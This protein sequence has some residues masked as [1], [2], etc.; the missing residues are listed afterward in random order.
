M[1][2]AR[3]YTCNV[4]SKHRYRL[5][6]Q[7]LESSSL[8]ER[9][10]KDAIDSRLNVSQQL[11]MAAKRVNN[12]L[13]CIK[14]STANWSTEVILYF[15]LMWPPL[16][17]NTKRILRSLK[18]PRRQQSWQTG[19]KVCPVRISWRHLHY[20]VWRKEGWETTSLLSITSWGRKMER[21][22]CVSFPW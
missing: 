12:T 6:V 17:H 19:W 20:L 8:T 5:G 13:G 10:L 22:V 14:H 21:R 16:L 4:I 9:D 1:V 18:V 2:N 7:W 3:L 15:L 11:A